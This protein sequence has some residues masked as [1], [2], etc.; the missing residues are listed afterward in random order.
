MKLFF[1]YHKY[2][3]VTSMLLD[4]QLPSFDMFNSQMILLNQIKG[5]SNIIT[6]HLSELS[7]RVLPTYVCACGL[8]TFV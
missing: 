1:G 7:T 3:S 4:V 8:L 5:S 2:S 6:K